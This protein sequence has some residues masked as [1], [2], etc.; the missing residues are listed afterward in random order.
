MYQHMQYRRD[1]AKKF[2]LIQVV[3]LLGQKCLSEFHHLLSLLL[4]LCLLH[5]HMTVVCSSL[6]KKGR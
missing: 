5:K 3:N 4:Q 6:H 1:L 2:S